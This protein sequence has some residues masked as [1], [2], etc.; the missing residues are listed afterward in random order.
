M[1]RKVIND[2]VRDNNGGARSS[3]LDDA[4]TRPSF[5]SRKPVRS[6]FRD[7]GNIPSEAPDTRRKRRWPW[8]VGLLFIVVLFLLSSVFSF[9][10]IK[11]TPRQTS[12]ALNTTLN[13]SKEQAATGSLSFQTIELSD[14]VT[15]E[16]SSTGTKNVE[17]KA[18]GQITVFNEYS[19]EPV[20]LIANT[21]FESPE[22]NIYRIS[23]AISVPGYKVVDGVRVPG[24][25]DALVT[26]DEPGDN[27]NIGPSRFSVPGL[28]D[29][30]RYTEVYAESTSA[31]A[32]GAIGEVP[33]V[34]EEERAQAE[35]KLVSALDS[36]LFNT[37]DS[38]VPEGFVLI[39]DASYVT[40]DP[41]IE[42]GSGLETASKV[43]LRQPGTI[44]GVLVKEESLAEVLANRN[45]SDYGGDDIRIVNIDELLFDLQEIDADEVAE[46][47]SI[48]L[49][50]SGNGV[51]VWGVDHDALIA[52]LIGTKKSNYEVI[53]SEYPTIERAEVFMR[54]PWK[55]KFPSNVEKM[56]VVESIDRGSE[57]SAN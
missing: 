57:E 6:T 56:R 23:S 51:F 32:G 21:R 49:V 50:V 33:V 40:Y 45:I 5:L 9:A 26:A 38:Q 37:I 8:V 18:S 28:K 39:K 35:D 4:S 31:I 34:D 53:F 3:M 11:I 12:V 30:P 55:R 48:T 2:V 10:T 22:G 16:I 44:H 47:E 54:P 36:L 29:D 15:A 13:V 7:I 43:S 46:A 42:D 41:P 24:T 25:L 14:E 19:K 27:Y 1:P 17:R 52:D 20:K